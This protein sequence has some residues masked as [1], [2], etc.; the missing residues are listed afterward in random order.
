LFG[1]SPTAQELDALSLSEETLF[2]RPA[3]D[4]KMVVNNLNQ[5]NPKKTIDNNLK[6]FFDIKNLKFFISFVKK[7]QK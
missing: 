1:L 6:F 4:R 2:P 3:T 7:H 5:Q